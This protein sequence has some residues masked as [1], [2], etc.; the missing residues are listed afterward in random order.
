LRP[1]HEKLPPRPDLLSDNAAIRQKAQ[2]KM[3]NAAQTFTNKFVLVERAKVIPY[4]LGSLAFMFGSGFGIGWFFRGWW[5]SSSTPDSAD[6][7]KI[8]G[9]AD[10]SELAK[11][12]D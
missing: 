10:S 7:N 2:E 1:T 5:S 12:I 3:A 11:I 6:S 8:P 4:L 9:T